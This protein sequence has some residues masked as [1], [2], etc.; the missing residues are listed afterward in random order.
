MRIE[1][2][3]QETKFIV[4]PIYF[5]LKLAALPDTKEMRMQIT[6][7]HVAKNEQTNRRITVTSETRTYKSDNDILKGSS[8]SSERRE[9]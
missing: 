8:S 7:R 6:T 4:L 3:G 5:M 9:L 1:C 2:V